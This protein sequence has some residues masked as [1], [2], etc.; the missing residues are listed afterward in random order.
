MKRLR[1]LPM[2]RLG[3]LMGQLGQRGCP[4]LPLHPPDLPSALA[5]SERG[6]SGKLA[7]CSRGPAAGAE[8]HAGSGAAAGHRAAALN[9]QRQHCTRLRPAGGLLC[10]QP[11]C[12]LASGR[13]WTCSSMPYDCNRTGK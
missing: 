11:A 7:P 10:M 5:L 8:L 9:Q 3:W 13:A 4:H 12:M 6:R 2:L 1:L